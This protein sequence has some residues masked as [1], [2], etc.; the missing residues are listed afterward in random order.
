MESVANKSGTQPQETVDSIAA[1]TSLVNVPTPPVC[2][3][4]TT[5]VDKRMQKLIQSVAEIGINLPWQDKSKLYSLLC[6]YHDSFV[7]E[8]GERGETGLV[9]MKI[10]TGHAIPKRQSVQRT[11][12]A[13]REEIAKQL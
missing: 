3:V 4:T 1:D 9:Q 11:P 13:A 8:D 10:D 6:E 12:F 7:L 5:D 2:S